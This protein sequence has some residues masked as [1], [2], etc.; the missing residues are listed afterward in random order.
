[1]PILAEQDFD[2]VSNVTMSWLEI[3]VSPNYIKSIWNRDTCMTQKQHA[4]E[5]W[6]QQE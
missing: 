4:S 1:M 3:M 2:Y 5:H 6:N